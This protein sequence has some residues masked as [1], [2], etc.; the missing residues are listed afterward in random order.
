M[1]QQ[2]SSFLESGEPSKSL[3]LGWRA[4]GTLRGIESPHPNLWWK[5]QLLLLWGVCCLQ[6]HGT[7]G[8]SM[9]L[10]RGPGIAA[11]L[12]AWCHHSAGMQTRRPESPWLCRELRKVPAR[13]VWSCGGGVRC[14]P[15]TLALAFDCSVRPLTTSQCPW[16]SQQGHSELGW[17]VL[18]T[19]LLNH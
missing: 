8:G 15:G 1:C 17:P 5:P 6:P 10:G 16:L 3:R 4:C 11:S 14:C 7:G 18:G 2:V 9:A 12:W 13:G 19:V